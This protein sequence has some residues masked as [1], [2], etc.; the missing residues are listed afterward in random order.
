MVQDFSFYKPLKVMVICETR[1]TVAS[2]IG[3]ENAMLQ[4]EIQIL[5]NEGRNKDRK[6]ELLEAEILKLERK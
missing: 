2:R 6:I 5:Q 3:A 1:H 4:E